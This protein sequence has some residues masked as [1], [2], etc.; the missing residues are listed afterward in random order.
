MNATRRITFSSDHLVDQI[1]EGRKTASAEWVQRQGEIDEWDAALEVGT[2]YAVCDSQRTVRCTIR[3]TSIRL[4]R[5]DSI[6]Q[7]LWKGETNSTPEEFQ[8]DH[9]DYFDN[10]GNDFEFVGFE[11]ELVDVVL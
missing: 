1:I 6:P 2:V 7:W 11:F 5:W 8:S 3:L 9:L 4:C 10:P